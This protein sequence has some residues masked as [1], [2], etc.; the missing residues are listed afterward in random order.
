ML[1]FRPED[2]GD[3]DPEVLRL[4]L[5]IEKAFADVPYPGYENLVHV[6]R[7][8]DIDVAEHFKDIKWQDLKNNPSQ[9]LSM[10][11]DGDLFLL[12]DAAFRYYLPLYMIQALIDYETADLLPG[13]IILS[14]APVANNQARNIYVSQ[15]ISL[16]SPAQLK[17]IF[18]Y[19]KF[20]KREHEKDFSTW[21]ID[22]AIVNIQ[23]AIG[24]T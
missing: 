18:S 12:S 20:F 4:K 17:V 14:F 9:F 8:E 2:M 7:P 1:L 11:L 24:N 10:R 21:P 23:R 22:E 6:Q 19:L 15:R 13:E 16:M 3:I 5:D